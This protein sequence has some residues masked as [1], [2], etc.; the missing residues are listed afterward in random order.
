MQIIYISLHTWKSLQIIRPIME[1]FTKIIIMI[2]YWLFNKKSADVLQRLG[3][4]RSSNLKTLSW[5]VKQ[6]FNGLICP[7]AADPTMYRTVILAVFPE[8]RSAEWVFGEWVFGW[9]SIWLSEYL[10]ESQSSRLT[11]S[12]KLRIYSCYEYYFSM[13]LSWSLSIY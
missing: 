6:T 9:V 4:F 7:L 11:T 8:K 3:F 2:W 10:V 5:S 13:S 12:Q 1:K